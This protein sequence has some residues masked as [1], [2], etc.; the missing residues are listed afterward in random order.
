MQTFVV[1]D[2]REKQ[3]FRF[4]SFKDGVETIKF[5]FSPWADSNGTLTAI[6]ATVKS[7]DA[8]ISNES[9]ASN[10]KTFSLTTSSAGQSMI[11]I[12][13][14]AGNNT[15]VTHLSVFTKDPNSQ[16]WDYGIIQL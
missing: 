3:I 15:Y 14:T 2:N 5:D 1:R 16:V 12:K 11:Q 10:V 8:A 4:L 13:G 9:L 7:G 6:T